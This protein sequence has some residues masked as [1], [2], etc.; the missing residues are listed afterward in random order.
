MYKNTKVRASDN[1]SDIVIRPGWNIDWQGKALFDTKQLCASLLAAPK[2]KYIKKNL[3]P[4]IN[5]ALNNSGKLVIASVD[6][7]ALGLGDP[8]FPQDKVLLVGGV[9]KLV[10]EGDEFYIGKPWQPMVDFKNVDSVDVAAKV[11]DRVQGADMLIAHYARYDIGVL[12]QYEPAIEERFGSFKPLPN[13]TVDI[14]APVRSFGVS[15]SQAHVINHFG[16]GAQKNSVNIEIW[17]DSV[18]GWF[19]GMSIAER[20]ASLFEIRDTRNKGCLAENIA[21]L[22]FESRFGFW[23]NKTSVKETYPNRWAM[24]EILGQAKTF[25]KPIRSLE[26]SFAP[27]SAVG[28]VRKTTSRRK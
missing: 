26:S 7:E 13:V 12:K 2:S 20:K 27:A 21:E 14:M 9:Q 3:V 19:N 18:V 8:R 6:T 10:I 5:D 23:M 1:G 25:A 22:A 11:H 17:Q 28:A 16:L 15:A 4:K 24:L